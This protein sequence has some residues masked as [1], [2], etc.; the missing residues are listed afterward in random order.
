MPYVLGQQSSFLLA[1]SN[2]LG[3]IWSRHGSPHKTEKPVLHGVDCAL[4]FDDVRPLLLRG[5]SSQFL[6]GS[7]R[8]IWWR[9]E[10]V[11]LREPGRIQGQLSPPNLLN[12]WVDVPEWPAQPVMVR[13]GEDQITG[14]G[15]R[16]AERG[17][18]L[19]L[20]LKHRFL[21]I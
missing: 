18:K 12:G 4:A 8:T 5:M 14:A 3:G 10:E 19:S 7:Q 21:R 13:R 9:C 16:L 11:I 6:G 20:S 17:T 2:L 15:R 1:S